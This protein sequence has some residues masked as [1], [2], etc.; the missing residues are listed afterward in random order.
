MKTVFLRHTCTYHAYNNLQ[1][2]CKEMSSKLSIIFS[3]SQF[4]SS[5]ALDLS[6]LFFNKLA[7]LL[8][9]RYLF[10]LLVIMQSVLRIAMLPARLVPFN[11]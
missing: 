3:S 7:K 5:L 6:V 1:A 10:F 2:A 4:L 11:D 8:I 9:Y